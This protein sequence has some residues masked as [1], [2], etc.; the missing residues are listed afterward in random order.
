[1]SVLHNLSSDRTSNQVQRPG[2]DQSEGSFASNKG[3]K[4]KGITTLGFDTIGFLSLKNKKVV[5]PVLKICK[6]KS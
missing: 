1:M 6:K 5:S 3:L 4:Q 2:F